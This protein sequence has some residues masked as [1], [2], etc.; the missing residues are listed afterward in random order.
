MFAF[1][2]KD[3]RD[4]Y[5]FKFVHKGAKSA[6]KYAVDRFQKLDAVSKA[7]LL[8]AFVMGFVG[9]ASYYRKHQIKKQRRK[10]M[11]HLKWAATGIAAFI[12]V[13]VSVILLRYRRNAAKAEALEAASAPSMWDFGIS[14]KSAETKW[15]FLPLLLLPTAVAACSLYLVCLQARSLLGPRS[16]PSGPGVVAAAHKDRVKALSG[17][18]EIKAEGDDGRLEGGDERRL[19]RRFVSAPSGDKRPF[20]G[21]APSRRSRS[22][23]SSRRSSYHNEIE[24]T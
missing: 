6:A 9:L 22:R 1:G 4:V 15:R 7:V 24:S 11:K 2:W 3:L 17:M 20:P 23:S 14:A 8:L 16:D 10:R 12:G 21:P 5:S 18:E 13:L 19:P